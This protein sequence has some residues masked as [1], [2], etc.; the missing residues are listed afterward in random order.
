MRE[1]CFTVFC[2]TPVDFGSVVADMV[3]DTDDYC[4]D[5]SGSILYVAQF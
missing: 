5:R 3:A 1:H 4:D 2:L